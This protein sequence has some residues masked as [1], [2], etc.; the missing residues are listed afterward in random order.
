MQMDINR[1]CLERELEKFID[2]GAAEDA[3]TVYYCYLEMLPTTRRCHSKNGKK[4]MSPS[5]VC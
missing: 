4:T 3:Y 2:S 5:T 1:L